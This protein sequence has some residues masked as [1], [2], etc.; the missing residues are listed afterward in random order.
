MMSQISNMTCYEN[1]PL[2]CVLISEDNR[3]KYINSSM[4]QLFNSSDKKTY[5]GKSFTD[6]IA[7]E[8]QKKFL[9]LLE[10]LEKKPEEERWQILRIVCQDSTIKQLIFNGHKRVDGHGLSSY[11]LVCAP[12]NLACL[13]DA[14]IEKNNQ[15]PRDQ[16]TENH[17]EYLFNRAT[18][19]IAVLNE[20]GLIDET[21]RAF[22]EHFCI[23]NSTISN[24]E[25]KHVFS[26]KTLNKFNRLINILNKSDQKY[27]KDVL[28]IKDVEGK[29]R[30]LEISL[31]ELYNEP[32]NS[33]KI[34][35]FT[36]DITHQQDTHTAMLQSEKLALTG[37][38]AASL[39][40]EINNPLQTSLGCLGLVE[41]MLD[42]VKDKDL[43]VYINMA[44]DELKRSARIVKRLRDLNRSTDLSE[45]SAVDVRKIIKGVLVL[46]KNHL[47]DKQIVPVFP[48]HGPPPMVSASEDQIQQVVLNL[49]MNAID[50]L[51]NGGNI[52][53]DIILTE[54][55]E[56]VSIKIRDTGAGIDPDIKK[57]M[58]DPFFTTKEDGLGL[59]LY[60]CKNIIED[61]A[62][63]LDYESEP[64]QGTE[65][66]IWLPGIDTTKEKE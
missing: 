54:K 61:H 5:I 14:C 15:D 51:P 24:Q 53:F 6:E 62:G 59:G 22:M 18:I 47:Y 32:D 1:L 45:R 34:M 19:G 17:F 41:E 4:S 39:A 25:N 37:R 11:F 56:G 44:I 9:N 16:Q 33:K 58:F 30:I 40:H 36:E 10:N 57:N 35:L 28:Y 3:I 7:P 31:S 12:I 23:E 50:A 52:F 60:N 21:N 48:Y 46:I 66:S 55:P 29:Q 43:A 26:R 20:S 49:V 64:G 63:L 8:D 65:F 38:L 13:R 42:D 27:V 2:A